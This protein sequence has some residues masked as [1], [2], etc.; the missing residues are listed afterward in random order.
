MFLVASARPASTS[1]RIFA[2]FS[3]GGLGHGLLASNGI[4]EENLVL[5]T[6]ALHHGAEFFGKPQ[7]VTIARAS[8]V[9]CSMS[10]Y[11]PDGQHLLL[12]GHDHRALLRTHHDLVF[13]VLE[14]GYVGA[15]FL[16][17]PP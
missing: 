3:R 10:D 8:L 17:F 11:A 16:C 4:A 14:L 9:A 12:F 6:I 7:C 2:S 5:I 15:S 13:R 1:R